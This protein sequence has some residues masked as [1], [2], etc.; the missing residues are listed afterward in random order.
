MPF[1]TPNEKENLE[2]WNYQ[3]IDNSISTKLLTA[4]WNWAVTLIPE[5]VAP[6]ILSL[7]GLLCIL[8]SYYLTYL[9]GAS[10][11]GITTLLSAVLLF[12]YQ[13]LD[14]IDGKHA[15]I[16]LNS[17]PIGELFD[18]ACD[19][20]GIVFIVL[21]ITEC[22]THTL[23]YMSMSLAITPTIPN[24]T[25]IQIIPTII[26]STDQWYLIHIFQ[27]NFLIYHLNALNNKVLEFPI[28]TGP[29]EGLLI[30]VGMLLLIGFHVSTISTVSDIFGPISVL[31]SVISNI[32]SA[33]PYITLITLAY[34]IYKVLQMP[35][36]T[37]NGLGICLIYHLFH[38]YNATSNSFT[39]MTVDVIANGI[40]F[41]VLATDIILAK[42]A[43]RDLHPWIPI[44]AG[45]SIFNPWISIALSTIYY[46]GI[47]IELCNTLNL[48]MFTIN[49][50]VY[51][52]G[53][54]D[55]CHLGHINLFKNALQFG[56]RLIVGVISDEDASQYKRSPIMTLKER[57]AAVTACK[58]V[59]KVI[60]RAPCFGLTE[61][62]LKEH[63][64]H[65]V[66][67][68]I[69]YD[70]PDDKYYVI[71]REMG[72]TK[73]LPRTEGMST[74]D[75]LNRMNVHTEKFLKETQNM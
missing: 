51:V 31:P 47:F 32:Q 44:L 5:D 29:G 71:P 61:E 22:L 40:S 64:I 72:I 13:T 74:T 37:R 23:N 30:I 49:R 8:Q 28:Y 19:N 50:N 45:F 4:F 11:P 65:V 12:A 21:T 75:L 34:L 55:L 67:H 9:C 62:F 7:A 68:S 53:I 6:N 39:I 15:R 48:H 56:N 35:Y 52:D 2:K 70:K 33:L 26:T 18:H 60:P 59:H 41:S 16:T 27:Y 43:K 14:A 36:S 58:G 25:V 10:Y 24:T 38:L 73:V 57:V 63:K 46:V 42:M 20:I 3:V 17:S 54:Y 69:E 1:F 66:V